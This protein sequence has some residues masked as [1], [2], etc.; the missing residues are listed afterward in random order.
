M[1][2]MC[3][4]RLSEIPKKHVMKRWTLDARDIL[5]DHLK[6][7]Q[8]DIGLNETHTFRHSKMYIAALELVKMGDMNVAAYEAVMKCLIDA[9]LKVTPLCNKT[10]GMSIVE[11]AAT[12]AKSN[13]T[14]AVRANSNG[15]ST[16]RANSNGGS[17]VRA[18]SNGGSATHGMGRPNSN[19]PA[20][21]E[22][23]SEKATKDK[24][25]YAMSEGSC[26]DGGDDSLESLNDVYSPDRSHH[27]LAPPPGKKR[28][29]RPTTAR[30]KA[31]YENKN[32]R[33]R[34]CTICRLEG[35]KRTTCPIRGDA[36]MKPRQ[37][38]RCSNC[39]ITGH[40]RTSCVK[41]ISFPG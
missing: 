5:P 22:L 12:M 25:K 30:D 4:L 23:F 27:D 1:Q 20:G 32:K 19:I 15:G 26:V 35:H 24:E 16:V 37:A 28:R 29:G 13:G 9:K 41:P 6:H 39:G 10:D 33:S 21:P 8:K 18:K 11:K 14:S 3:E 2:V 31:P 36:P 38:A 34:F 7:Y 40:R 17:T